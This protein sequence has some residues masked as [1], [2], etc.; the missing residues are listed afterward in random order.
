V[1]FIVYKDC[2]HTS[3]FKHLKKMLLVTSA[4]KLLNN[5]YCALMRGSILISHFL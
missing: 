4:G 1:D 5:Q 3:F 2:G